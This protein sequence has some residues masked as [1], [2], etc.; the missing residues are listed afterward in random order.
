MSGLSLSMRRGILL[1]LPWIHRLGIGIGSI[2]LIALGGGFLV[3]RSWLEDEIREG[4]DITACLGGPRVAP[5]DRDGN[6]NFGPILERSDA[7][8]FHDAVGSIARRMGVRPPEEIRLAYL[9]CC[10]VLTRRRRRVLLIGLPLLPVLTRGEFQAV[11]AHELAHLARGD[12]TRIMDAIRYVEAL[13]RGLDDPRARTWG[14]L[15]AWSAACRRVGEAVAAPIARGQEV[16]ADRVSAS[17]AGGVVAASA[18]A[19]VAMVQPLFREVLARFSG[20]G[21]GSP[22]L[23]ATFRGLWDRLPEPFREE[24]RRRLQVDQE[25]APGDPHPPLA[26]RLTALQRFPDRAEAGTDALPAWG[27]L[28]DPEWLEEML[29]ESLFRRMEARP[30]VFH[31]AGS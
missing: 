17:I 11:L 8:L 20:A 28:N 5:T 9:P 4:S 22:N 25:A 23:F 6:A 26:D 10:G 1:G 29:H 13:G 30:N 19:K 12:A 18:L 27:L 14:P 2:G 15:R 16:R 31:R 21:P 3:I 24:M 7:P